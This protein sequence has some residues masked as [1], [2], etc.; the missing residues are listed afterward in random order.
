MEQALKRNFVLFLNSAERKQI[1][2]NDIFNES[3]CFIFYIL[4][5]VGAPGQDRD[6]KRSAGELN[7]MNLF[8]LSKQTEKNFFN[9]LMVNMKIFRRFHTFSVVFNFKKT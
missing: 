5:R 8:Y 1:R 7:Q 9:E 6:K 2:K 4:Y 3:D